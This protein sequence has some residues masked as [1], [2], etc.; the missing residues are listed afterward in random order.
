MN[1]PQDKKNHFYLVKSIGFT[2]ID[3]S[4]CK[5]EFIFSF[6]WIFAMSAL[7]C[8]ISD[9]STFNPIAPSAPIV[10]ITKGNI[11]QIDKCAGNSKQ[12]G[13]TPANSTLHKMDEFLPGHKIR[14]TALE[15]A[16]IKPSLVIGSGNFFQF[17]LKT[18]RLISSY[19]L[20]LLLRELVTLGEL[21]F[22]ALKAQT[23]HE[24]D[25]ILQK[26]QS[27]S[28]GLMRKKG[29]ERWHMRDLPKI[30]SKRAFFD[31]TFKE[32]GFLP[33]ELKSNFVSVDHC[34]VFGARAECMQMRI[35]QTLKAFE[36]GVKV[37]DRIFLLSSNRPL[38]ED[39]IAYVMLKRQKLEA[40]YRKLKGK[41][42]AK[43][44]TFTEASAMKFLW[45][46]ATFSKPSLQKRANLI[47]SSAIRCGATRI[48]TAETLN[49]WL[50]KSRGDRSRSFFCFVEQPFFRL[51]DQLHWSILINQVVS[52]KDLIKRVQ[53]FNFHCK[54]GAISPKFSSCVVLDEIA[55]NVHQVIERLDFCQ[56]L[57]RASESFA[58]PILTKSMISRHSLDQVLNNDLHRAKPLLY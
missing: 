16:Q 9:K 39:E 37:I 38:L 8:A 58:R 25:D 17:D 2:L 31:Q 12:R 43:P 35:D 45:D 4:I 26:S 27:A 44:E 18:N 20:F 5:F 56:K 54:T 21:D 3:S 23:L 14:G 48:T 24:L 36:E 49:D 22:R 10:E 42:L 33:Q 13:L 30:D 53:S 29:T 7:H 52:K 19:P 40:N 57:D 41:K 51:A 6:A 15:I 47:C 50:Q 28:G 32:L 34:I 46:I 11:Q 1:R 55:R